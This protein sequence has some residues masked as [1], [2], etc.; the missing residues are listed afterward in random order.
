MA[1]TEKQIKKAEKVLSN[2]IVPTTEKKLAVQVQRTFIPAPLLTRQQAILRDM[3]GSGERNWGTGR[4]LPVVNNDLNN[5][6]GGGI[7]KSRDNGRTGG[8]FGMRR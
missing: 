2:R 5:P 4:N 3:F 6:N 7:I 8:F 1:T